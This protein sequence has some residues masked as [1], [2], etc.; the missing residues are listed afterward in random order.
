[1]GKIKT[2][3]HTGKKRANPTGVPSAA[4]MAR[5]DA[6]MMDT[7]DAAD[8]PATPLK[9]AAATLPLI[10]KLVASAP[11]DRVWA[12]A[13][14]ANLVHDAGNRKILLSKGL[15]TALLER[16][17]NETHPEVL[18]EVTG[19]L[20]N[21]VLADSTQANELG[22]KGVVVG[23]EK[24][25]VTC[26]GLLEA[27]FA[28][29]APANTDE[30]DARNLVGPLLTNAFSLLNVLCV[31]SRRAVAAVSQAPQSLAV[32]FE[33]VS[34][35]DKFQRPVVAAATAL[36]EI[37]TEDNEAI[38]GKIAPEVRAAV[39][40]LVDHADV[41]VAVAAAGI[42]YNLRSL[43]EDEAW[44]ARVLSVV[45]RVLASE[46]EQLLAEVAK[47]MD[48]AAPLAADDVMMDVVN[49]S[50]QKDQV[51][52]EGQVDKV[53]DRLS[54]TAG[55]VGTA[56][57][58][59]ANLT[60]HVVEPDSKDANEWMDEEED[61]A[62]GD[63][64]DAD[65]ADEDDEAVIAAMQDVAQVDRIDAASTND[66]AIIQY[67][68]ATR[69]PLQVLFAQTL[70]TLLAIAGKA[71]PRPAADAEITSNKTAL[72]AQ[73]QGL[74]VRAL[75]VLNN[76][77]FGVLAL[78]ASKRGTH[79]FP[80]LNLLPPPPQGASPRAVTQELYNTL[81]QLLMALTA[82][83]PEAAVASNAE[84]NSDSLAELLS[85]TL[86]AIWGLLKNF[87]SPVDMGAATWA[88]IPIDHIN[89]F[90]QLYYSPSATADV[91]VKVI[92]VLGVV[93]KRQPG[94]LEANR[95]I[96]AHLFSLMRTPKTLPAAVLV[97]VLNAVFDVYGDKSFDYDVFFRESDALAVLKAA[98]DGTR[99][100]AKGI[101]RRKQRALRDAC[102]EAVLNLR[103]FI[104]YKVAEYRS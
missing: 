67:V 101:D 37:V 102:D 100:V 45:Q 88:A 50:N 90:I 2:K 64:D 42:L 5:A 3:K 66:A 70:P 22:Q 1:M 4:D 79:P 24:L 53:Y 103:E 104:K 33:V 51:P 69:S 17:Q 40:A 36:L 39:T 81:V 26:R 95:V 71:P 62:E 41:H 83:A 29:R 84:S 16:L 75:A 32:L 46:H 74:R 9:S 25:L 82:L 48:A 77:F 23:L 73:A 21:L 47:Y 85:M 55:S 99:A 63:V 44:I 27:Q 94:H 92:G 93:G 98:L 72:L 87:D 59:L 15:T 68:E 8:S 49:D 78:P 13:G 20:R 96:G 61:V 43:A 54:S 80:L 31:A 60:T 14:V 12:A 38:Y 56:L 35:A 76:L 97:E 58:L 30:E 19:A 86:G 7:D 65:I 28:G 10:S 57:E 89:G 52:V 11:G 6:Q 91:Q 18:L 34:A